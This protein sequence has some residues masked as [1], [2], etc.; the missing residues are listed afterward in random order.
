MDRDPQGEDGYTAPVSAIPSKGG[1]SGSRTLG[2]CFRAFAARLS[3]RVLATCVA[4]AVA[5]RVYVGGWSWRDLVVVG[6]ML[7]FAPFFEWAVH[8]VVLHARPKRVGRFTIELPNAEDHRIHHEDPANLAHVLLPT[9]TLPINLVAIAVVA[10]GAGTLVHAVFGG[11]WNALAAAGLMVS[12]L[13]LFA[14]EWSHFLM[15]S[16]YRPRTRYFR[17]IWKNHRL[18]HYKNEHHWFGVTSVVADHALG[19]APDQTVVERSDT[20]RSLP[21]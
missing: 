18:H 9:R 16:P 1:G 17:S 12:A 6:F 20:V 3:P 2:E 5:L 10:V 8:V 14:Y 13:Y 19:T 21:S 11:D 15:H 7:V 4:L